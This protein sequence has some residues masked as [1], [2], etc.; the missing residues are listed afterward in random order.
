[1]INT[2][3]GTDQLVAAPSAAT[4]L[5]AMLI[6]LVFGFALEQAGFGSSRKLAAI[7]YF[8]DMTV[9]KVMFSALITAMLGLS[10]VV[11]LGGVDLGSQVYVLPTLYGAQ[12]VGGLVFGVGFVLS[13]WCPGTGAVGLASGKLDALVFLVGVV[14]G[15][16]VYNETY[17]WTAGLLGEEGVLMAF[18]LPRGLFALLFTLAAVGAFYF[19]EWVERKAGGCGKYLNTPFLRAFCILLVIAAVAVLILPSE[20]GGGPMASAGAWSEQALLEAVETAEDHVEPEELADALMQ[21]EQGLV[22]VDVRTPGEYRAFHIAGAVN[23]PLPELI[24]YLAPLKN[25]GRIVLYS[26]GMTHPAQARDALARLGYTEVFMLTDGLQ[27]FLDRCLMP[28]SLR[29]EPLAEPQAARVRAWRAFFLAAEGSDATPAGDAAGAV[30]EPTGKASPLLKTAWLAENFDR[31]DVKIIDVRDQALYN[32]SHVP[33]SLALHPESLR[34]VVGGVP[35]VLL[36]AE[37]LA[38]QLGLMGL[39]PADMVVIV[40]GDKL[41]DATLVG[42][43]LDRV[44]QKQWGIL[45]GGFDQWAAEKRP[46]DNTLPAVAATDYQ[47]RSGADDFTVDHQAV[48]ATLGDKRTVI[49]DARPAPYF[50]GEKSDE[51]RAG[52]IPGAVNRP[53]SEDLRDDGQPKSLPE[54][55]GAYEAIVPSKD[56]P[57]IVHCRTGHQASQTYFVLRHVLGYRNVKWYDGGWTDWAPRPELPVEK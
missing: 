49:I 9:L 32:T 28:V 16:I 23:V 38:A 30:V 50:T 39:T 33:G 51:A 25:Q 35:S 57:V 24:D 27:G 11:A 37:M 42:M 4:F 36:P 3:Y 18:G 44:G 45:E 2:F 26:N 21:N 56:T 6:G 47:A 19:A 20:P 12:I 53:F 5:A 55:T 46:V 41:R 48:L 1:M 7:F 31:P 14:L 43:A 13:G 22:V 52:H 54:L 17:G 10:L 29:R 8:R 34:G 40:P 15:A